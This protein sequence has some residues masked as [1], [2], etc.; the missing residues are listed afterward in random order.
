MAAF[1]AP[2]RRA[3]RRWLRLEAVAGTAIGIA[4]LVWRHLRACAGARRTVD[5]RGDRR[6]C[7]SLVIRNRRGADRSSRVEIVY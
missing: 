6:R 5:A 4:L 2:L 3:E 1:S 7:S